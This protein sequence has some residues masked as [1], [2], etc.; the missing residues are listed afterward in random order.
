[1]MTIMKL[2]TDLEVYRR[3]R[4]SRLYP[5]DTGLNLGWGLEVVFTDLMHIEEKYTRC[6]YT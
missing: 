5:D 1:M 6:K 3:G 2:P 4:V